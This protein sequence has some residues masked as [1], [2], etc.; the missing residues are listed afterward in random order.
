MSV[1]REQINEMIASAERYGWAT[2]VVPIASVRSAFGDEPGHLEDRLRRRA[3]EPEDAMN[4]APA[5]LDRDLL[6]SAA[7]LIAILAAPDAARQLARPDVMRVIRVLDHCLLAL[8]RGR[9]QNEAQALR[10]DLWN[11]V[12]AAAGVAR[13][14]T[15]NGA[16][17]PAH[18]ATSASSR[19]DAPR[20]SPATEGRD[21][22]VAPPTTPPAAG[23]KP[24]SGPD[25]GDVVRVRS[26]SAWRVIADE[27]RDMIGRHQPG[28]G[29]VPGAKE[30]QP[31][32][33]GE[34]ADKKGGAARQRFRSDL[35]GN[36]PSRD[37]PEPSKH[38]PRS[39]AAGQPPSVGGRPGPET[40]RRS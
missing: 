15:G 33:P 5:A 11:T 36:E 39:A 29:G 24:R 9:A 14:G 21:R 40:D 28:R 30:Q 12:A 4:G 34:C 31:R 8:P 3:E 13:P 38:R 17:F 27:L 7:D 6:H 10:T 22:S 20:H 37:G 2:I 18:E 1:L 16:M 35:W 19:S 26:A 32:L 23:I 25:L